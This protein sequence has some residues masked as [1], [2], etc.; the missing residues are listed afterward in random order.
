M[1]SGGD[2]R[3]AA[4][5]LV[6]GVAQI[7]WAV[8][9]GACSPSASERATDNCGYTVAPIPFRTHIIRGAMGPIDGFRCATAKV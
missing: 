2:A 5:A 6:F 1:D 8:A 4:V 7:I 3:V 9:Q